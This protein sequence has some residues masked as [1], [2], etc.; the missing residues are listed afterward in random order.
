MDAEQ[1]ALTNLGNDLLN[2]LVASFHQKGR[3]A[4]GRTLNDITVNVEPGRMY[5]TGPF[6]LI[7]LE[8]G[9]RPTGA[10]G[11]VFR[12]SKIS[13]YDSL[14]LWIESRGIDKKAL[15]PIYVS[16]NKNGFP[17]TPGLI[18]K[19]LSPENVDKALDKNLGQIADLYTTQVL[20]SIF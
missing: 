11:P 16:I 4:S 14:K 7:N 5:I 9:R 20:Q 17:G 3:V 18:S 10:G 12:G 2:G 19:P 13:F 6:Y 8:K 15:F 1:K